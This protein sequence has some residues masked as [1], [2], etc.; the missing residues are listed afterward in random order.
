MT[1]SDRNAPRA[2]GIFPDSGELGSVDRP[3]TAARRRGNANRRRH[4]ASRDSAGTEDA[5]YAPVKTRLR[6]ACLATARD[7]RGTIVRH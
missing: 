5:F 1:K 6:D 3:T 2:D 7:S 4:T